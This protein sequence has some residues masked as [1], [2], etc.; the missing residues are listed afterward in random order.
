[1]T[2]YFTKDGD[3]FK[4]VDDTLFTQSEIDTN[5][6]PNRL[7]RERKK[8][9]DYDTLKE[10]AGKVDSIETEWKG[11][12]DAVVGEK[13]TLE[14]ELGKTKL[15]VEKVKIVNQF[16]LSDELAEFV[17]G[18]TADEMKARA[19]KLAKGFKGGKVNLSKKPKPGEE[20]DNSS[21]RKVARNLFGRNSS[22]A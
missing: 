12:L 17:T 8:Y 6:I 1:M 7:E 16:K 20:E 2:K 22:D 19:E 4:E 21:N 13:T 18:E 15:E 11:K 14:K 3:D 10:K 5:I 9:A